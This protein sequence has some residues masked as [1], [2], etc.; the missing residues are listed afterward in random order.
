M[1][2]P[3]CLVLRPD[4][5]KVLSVSRKKIVVHEECYAKFGDGK[6]PLAHFVIPVIDLDQTR[7][8]VKNL[9]KI[10]HYKAKYEIPDHVLSVKVLSDF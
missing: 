8:E 4:D 3:M 10:K 7:T 9:E 2:L 1:Q 5:K 6:N